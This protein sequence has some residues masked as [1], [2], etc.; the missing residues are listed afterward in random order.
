MTGEYRL[1]LNLGDPR[2]PALIT[3]VSFEMD[4]KGQKLIVEEAQYVRVE[5]LAVV[6][7]EELRMIA[8][9]D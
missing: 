4:D 9:T 8:G 5:A 6:A 1:N 2:P 7:D 3:V